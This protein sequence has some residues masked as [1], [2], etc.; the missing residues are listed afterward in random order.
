MSVGEKII[1]DFNPE[2]MRFVNGFS[3]G[4]AGKRDLCGAVAGA[5]VALSASFGRKNINGDEAKNRW[6][7]ANFYQRF[8]ESLG[9]TSCQAIRSFQANG[10]RIAVEMAT[11]I[12]LDVLGEEPPLDAN[13]QTS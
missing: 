11:K 7:C 12:A 10:C 9:T 3:G 1:P 6:F 2:W 13:I 5:I 8:V 4:I